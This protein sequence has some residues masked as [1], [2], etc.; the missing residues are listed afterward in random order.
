MENDMIVNGTVAEDSK[1]V[2]EIWQLRER[3]AEALQ[4][5]GYV[6]KVRQYDHRLC[7][8]HAITMYFQY[9]VSI[10]LKH[11]YDLVEDMRVR[12]GDKAL[13]CVGYGHVGDSNLHLV[14]LKI[15]R[16]SFNSFIRM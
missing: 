5:D 12:L 7:V 2:G 16:Q 8:R 15:S 4:H 11:F 1:K 10:P 14:S 13:R 9:D 6:Y 3:M